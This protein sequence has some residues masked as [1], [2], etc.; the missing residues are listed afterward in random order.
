M[1][2]LSGQNNTIDTPT[3]GSGCTTSCII[4]LAVGLGGGLLLLFVIIIV[5]VVLLRRRRST[6]NNRR[7]ST[8][9]VNEQYDEISDD[10]TREY[11]KSQRVSEVTTKNDQYDSLAK[12]RPVTVVERSPRSTIF[13]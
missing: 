10:N 3:G 6:S 8:V 12:E 5:L 7:S 4:G 13:P 1:V 2:F 9:H 11:E